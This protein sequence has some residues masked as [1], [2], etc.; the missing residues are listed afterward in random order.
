[1]KYF[2]M[3]VASVILLGNAM[4]AT[5]IVNPS[6]E[7]QAF[8]ARTFNSSNKNLA[9][10]ICFLLTDRK[11]FRALDFTTKKMTFEELAI[12]FSQTFQESPFNHSTRQK[13]QTILHDV[14][15]DGYMN[16]RDADLAHVNI[17]MSISS[18]SKSKVKYFSRI[19]CE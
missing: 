9:N 13:F 4:G 12:N 1:M 18:N 11:S 15:V 8:K 16:E 6:L 7:G 17:L 2:L 3:L 14:V 19:L 5:E 10:R